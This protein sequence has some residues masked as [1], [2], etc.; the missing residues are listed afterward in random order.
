VEKSKK[1]KNAIANRKT[2]IAKRKNAKRKTQ[3]A[4]D[5]SQISYHKVDDLACLFNPLVKITNIL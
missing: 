5:K 3:D 1:T 4:N 2:Q